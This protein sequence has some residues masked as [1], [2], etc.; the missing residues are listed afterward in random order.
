MLYGFSCIGFSYLIS[1]FF[2]R[3]KT[4]ATLCVPRARLW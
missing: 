2:S 3:A 4:A 1:V